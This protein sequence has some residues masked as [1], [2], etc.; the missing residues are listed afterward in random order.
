MKKVCRLTTE[1]KYRFIKLWKTVYGGL[2][3]AFCAETCDDCFGQMISE[4]RATIDHLTPLSKGGTNR[5]ENLVVACWKCNNQKADK[6][7]TEFDLKLKPISSEVQN[8]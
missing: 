5:R 1:R 6:D 8:A 7:F 3:C 4:K 2:I